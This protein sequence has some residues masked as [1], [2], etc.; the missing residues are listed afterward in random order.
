MAGKA[1]RMLLRGGRAHGHR[2]EPTETGENMHNPVKH[3]SILALLVLGAALSTT[4]DVYAAA[5][6]QSIRDIRDAVAEF[7]RAQHEHDHSVKITISK[8][9]SRLRLARCTRDL[10]AFHSVYMFSLSFM[11][12]PYTVP[13]IDLG[14]CE[15]VFW[16]WPAVT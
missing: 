4:R 2:L 7:A 11:A 1:A 16:P 3:P 8:L 9:D 10:D 5:E 13:N 6:Q 12:I 15:A 14:S